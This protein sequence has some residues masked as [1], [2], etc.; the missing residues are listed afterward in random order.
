MVLAERCKHICL[1][2]FPPCACLFLENHVYYVVCFDLLVRHGRQIHKFLLLVVGDEHYVS[3][4]S[5]REDLSNAR[6]HL[7]ECVARLHMQ[8]HSLAPPLQ[9]YVHRHGCSG[10]GKWK[11]KCN[12]GV[13]GSA[14]EEFFAEPRTA[15]R[16][17]AAE[18]P[19]EAQDCEGRARD[20]G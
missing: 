14:S 11:R 6:L 13:L 18:G 9:P 15:A 4:V 7:R 10:A 20:C 2:F 8:E 19:S 5:Y 12:L 3:G 17:S 1:Q 16:G